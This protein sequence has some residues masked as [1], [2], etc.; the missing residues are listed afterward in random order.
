MNQF[1]LLMVGLFALALGSI[2]GYYARQSIA[3]KKAGTIEQTLQKRLQK[4]KETADSILSEA[5]EKSQKI[6]EA[7]KEE[8]SQRHSELL[9]TERLLL[10]REHI[11]DQK[12]LILNSNRKSFRKR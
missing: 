12:F 1:I 9:R 11:L 5:K 7:T 10:K 4:A 8:T 6:L 3:K 2:L